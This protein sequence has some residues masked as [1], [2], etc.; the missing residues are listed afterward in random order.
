MG[1]NY[2]NGGYIVFTKQPLNRTN[3]TLADSV[4]TFKAGEPIYMTVVMSEAREIDGYG[5]NLSTGGDPVMTVG[6]YQKQCDTGTFKTSMYVDYGRFDKML[7]KVFALDF[8]P[9][10]GKSVKYQKQIKYISETLRGLKPG[11]HI[12]PVRIGDNNS[13][14]AIGLFYY[15]NRDGRA[16][17]AAIKNA[18][19]QIFMPK[20]NPKFA[21]AE[22]QMVAELNKL[23]GG[24]ALRA[25]VTDSDWT[26]L[27]NEYSGVLTGRAITAVMAVKTDDGGCFRETQSWGQDYNG[28][29]YT[30]MHLI[31]TRERDDMLCENAMK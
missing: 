5:A 20:A 15:D 16:N 18:M 17:D 12:V 31:G 11:V 3:P 7:P 27:R 1:N 30:N 26:P 13:S 4:M 25:I 2:G 24:K 22:K 14:M 21:A 28:S 19:A 6:D 29:A 8:Q 23:P 10:D 9:A